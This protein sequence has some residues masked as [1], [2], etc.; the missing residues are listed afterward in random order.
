MR[1]WLPQGSL[2]TVAGSLSIGCYSTL[3]SHFAESTDVLDPGSVGLTVAGGIAGLAEGCCKATATG[4]LVGGGDVRA[5]I[6]VGARQEVGASLFAGVGDG[7]AV[8]YELGGEASYK[9]APVSWLALVAGG[10]AMAVVD[11]STTAVL[12]GDLAAIVAPYTDPHGTQIYTGARGSIAAPILKGAHGATEAMTLPLGAA[13]GTR[14]PFRYFVE[15]GAVV[16]W[17]Q[18]HDEKDPSI[19]GNGTTLGGYGAAA[20]AFVLR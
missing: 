20:V 19:S 14:Q 7:S 15:V 11:P 18:Y 9:V 6:G 10:G 8:P 17:S 1:Q 3:P 2:V 16:A 4:R 13:I 12:G 5:R